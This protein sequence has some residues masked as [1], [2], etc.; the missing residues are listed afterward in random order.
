VGTLD[1]SNT[2]FKEETMKVS[3]LRNAKK[4]KFTQKQRIPLLSKYVIGEKFREDSLEER[5]G[6]LYLDP[7]SYDLGL[8]ITISQ[9]YLGLEFDE[10]DTYE[11]VEFLFSLPE[12]VSAY[13]VVLGTR[14]YEELLKMIETVVFEYQKTYNSTGAVVARFFSEQN[15]DREN[16]KM[17]D[18]IEQVQELIGDFDKEKLAYIKDISTSMAKETPI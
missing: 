18:M 14:D 1:N 13:N 7:A 16:K 3:E 11:S 2:G 6:V 9:E 5:D 4:I 10:D 12:F 15:T 8:V 17:T